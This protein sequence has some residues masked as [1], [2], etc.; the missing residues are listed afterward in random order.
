MCVDNKL[1]SYKAC[2]GIYYGD[3]NHGCVYCINV[4]LG[5]LAALL[6]IESLIYFIITNI[7]DYEYC[8]ALNGLRLITVFSCVIATLYIYSAYNNYMFDWVSGSLTVINLVFRF[9]TIVGFIYCVANE[10][11]FIETNQSLSAALVI[12]FI[13]TVV[14]LCAIITSSICCCMG[15]TRDVKKKYEDKLKD[16][17]L[18]DNLAKLRDERIKAKELELQNYE[19]KLRDESINI[20]IPV[21]VSV[22]GVDGVGGTNVIKYEIQ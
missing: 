18:Q 16:L 8:Y 19:A 6:Y 22:D 2:I 15:C 1:E 17:E 14:L 3:K 11:S 13:F 10:D 4:C 5:F 9:L 12:N 20:A 7:Y 21:G